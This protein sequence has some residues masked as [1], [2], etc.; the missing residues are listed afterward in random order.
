[1]LREKIIMIPRKLTCILI[2][3]SISLIFTGCCG[4]SGGSGA[5]YNSIRTYSTY[6]SEDGS[7]N[8]EWDGIGLHALPGTFEPR[9]SITVS[10]LNDARGLSEL[11]LNTSDV[12][13][14]SPVFGI[15]LEPSQEILNDMATVTIDISPENNISSRVYFAVKRDE[16]SLVTTNTEENSNPSLRASNNAQ[17]KS[18]PFITAFRFIALAKI[19]EEFINQDPVIRFDNSSNSIINQLNTSNLTLF[20]ELSTKANISEEFKKGAVFRLNLRADKNEDADNDRLLN[21]GQSSFP[22]I[23]RKLASIYKKVVQGSIDLTNLH[24]EEPSKNTFIYSVSCNLPDISYNDIPRRVVLETQFVNSKNL[25]ITSKEYVIH[26]KK[27]RHP[28]ATSV[29]PCP[30]SFITNSE[31]L[32]NIVVNFSEPMDKASVESATTVTLGDDTYS[33]SNNEKK[34]TFEWKNN[35]CQLNIKSNFPLSG[36]ESAINVRIKETAKSA[37]TGEQ[38]SDKFNSK[39]PKELNWTF[40]Y[41]PSDFYVIMTTPVPGSINNPV[42]NTD[43]SRTGP[44]ITLKFSEFTP[45]TDFKTK[46]LLYQGDREIN[47]TIK[48]QDMQ[49]NEFT[50]IPEEILEFNKEYTV[51]AEK[52]LKNLT[53]N[54]Q[55]K[56]A[57]KATFETK[58]PF[59]SGRG[60]E[61]DP[62]IITNQSELNNIKLPKF[63][64]SDYFFKLN[65]DITIRENVNEGEMTWRP[66]GD[67]NT[68]FKGHFDGN[69][70]TI[71]NLVIKQ[72]SVAKLGLFGCITGSEIKNLRIQ[73][74]TITGEKQVGTVVGFCLN[75]K[76]SNILAV[77]NINIDASEISGCIV[78]EALSTKIENCQVSPDAILFK[79]GSINGGIAG[80]IKMASQIAKSSVKLAT[81]TLNG[82]SSVGGIVGK[83]DNSS[84]SDSFFEG[85]I[86]STKDIGCIVGKAS[87]TSIRFCSAKSSEIDIETASKDTNAG[88]ICGVLSDSSSI[89][90]SSSNVNIAGTGNNIGGIVGFI[91][92]S[93]ISDAYADTQESP[94][95]I[96]TNTIYCG[97]IVGYS[98]NSTLNNLVSRAN[99]AGSDYVGGIAGHVK[100]STIQNS[101]ALLK[102]IKSSSDKTSQVNRVLGGSENSTVTN[103]YGLEETIFDYTGA[104]NE[105]KHKYNEARDG[106]LK[107]EATITTELGALLN[108]KY[109]NTS[110]KLE[111]K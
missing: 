111:M 50:F 45:I 67:I 39:K 72:P 7:I 44:A 57:Y 32:K 103:I 90:Y 11:G 99:I 17:K 37:Y 100:D 9:T 108:K 33:S 54:K 55:L 102:R 48:K 8:E 36:N 30:D 81:K 60:F 69:G 20:S 64:N 42:C 97:G 40:N 51:V 91:S 24:I 73:G 94:I 2:I 76:I 34:L 59:A 28:F 1:M 104:S 62:F 78:G 5:D 21:L 74:S 77:G 80:S 26:F 85:K 96:E 35:D 70:K 47:Y 87:K 18:L 95:D 22:I 58:D 4:S 83:S 3:L 75:S 52:G 109:W 92:D 71:S 98:N 110:P 106:K 6:A 19:E 25:P 107:S 41:S 105:Y 66:I 86:K 53:G 61:D 29:W 68:P 16:T 93:R 56:E 88:G 63:I 65:N 82:T 27:A 12:T 31:Q 13:L 10:I 89:E 79:K 15:K 49:T 46:I 38:I 84:I 101:A 14:M 23:L 43:D